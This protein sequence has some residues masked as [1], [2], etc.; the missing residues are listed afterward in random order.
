M[1][2]SSNNGESDG[3]IELWV[4]SKKAFILATSQVAT[5][6]PPAKDFVFTWTKLWADFGLKG[7]YY[8]KTVNGIEYI[9]FKGS[10]AARQMITGTRYLAENPKVL[11]MAIGRSGIIDSGVKGCKLSLGLVGAADAVEFFLRDDE[12]LSQFGVKL[13]SDLTKTMIASVIAT[14]VGALAATLGAPIIVPL[15]ITIAVGVVATKGLDYL[16]E[17]LELTKKLQEWVDH[18]TNQI[19]R[20]LDQARQ[21]LNESGRQVTEMIEMLIRAKQ[22]YDRIEREINNLRRLFSSPLPMF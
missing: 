4:F 11:S 12:T 18:S 2:S 22:D 3:D 5:Y 1:Q 17:K 19:S 20:L 14:A 7:R 6:T 16:D 15:A 13:F 9:I 8:I 10:P 21:Q